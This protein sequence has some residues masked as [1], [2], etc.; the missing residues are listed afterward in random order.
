MDR[1]VNLDP[2]RD[3][4]IAPSDD[5]HLCMYLIDLTFGE[6]PVES[7]WASSRRRCSGPSM[8]SS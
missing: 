2:L 4:V 1:V 7:S 6:E 3:R 5:A 8:C